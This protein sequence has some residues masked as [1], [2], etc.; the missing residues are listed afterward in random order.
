MML[1]EWI[2]ISPGMSVSIIAAVLAVTIA[3]SLRAP[4]AAAS[5]GS[6]VG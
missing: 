1:N 6:E 5:K 3:T 4:R 2:H